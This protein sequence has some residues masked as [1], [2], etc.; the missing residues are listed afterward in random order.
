MANPVLQ[1]LITAKDEASSAFGKLF[2]F[3]DSEV[4]VVAGKIRTAF[5]GLFGGGLD[6]AIEFE[7]QLD[8]VQAKGGYTAD[9]MATLKKAAT[10]I[11]ATFGI[12]G[13]QAAEGMES[14]AAAGLNAEQ[15]METLP[16]VLSLA[17]AEALSMDEASNLLANSLTTVGLGF[18]QAARLADVLTQAANESTTSATAVGAALETA[19]GIARTAGLDLEQTVAA[20]TGLAKGGIEGERAGTALAAILTQLLNPAS[21]ASKELTA[22]GITSRDLG[23]VVGE[24]EKRGA[25]ANTAILAFGETAGPGLRSLIAQG[26]GS[27]TELEQAMLRSGGAAQNAADQMSGNLKGALT[28]LVSAWENVKTAL[29][30]PVLETLAEAARDASTALN[31][32]LNNGALQP[33]QA[34]IKSFTEQG[35][36]AVREFISN[37]DFKAALTSVQGFATNAKESFDS[38]KSAGQT[39]ADV[40]T[41]AWNGLTAGF[42][43]IGA[44]LLGVASS[45]LG[46]LAAIESAAAKVGLGSV[47][48][49]NELNAKALAMK[50]TAADLLNQVATGGREMGVAFERLT[51]STAAAAQAQQTLKDSLPVSEIQEITKTLGDY[52]RIAERTNA[53]AAV[54]T[55]E[56]NAGK[57]SAAEYGAK[58]LAAA[59]ANARLEEETRKTAVATKDSVD[60]STRLANER[61]VEVKAATDAAKASGTYAEALQK[62]GDAAAEVIRAEI[63]LA[64]AKGDVGAAA[65]LA[66]KLAKQEAD[67]AMTVA[68][69]KEEEAR[70][71]QISYEKQKDYLAAVGG[72]T[73]VQKQELELL[74]LKAIALGEEAKAA[75]IGAEIKKLAAIQSADKTAVDKETTQATKENTQATEK[76]SEAQQVNIKHTEDATAAGKAQNE[77]LRQARK[78]TEELSEATRRL[79]DLEFSGAALRAGFDAYRSYRDA[80]T[81]YKDGVDAGRAALT[82]FQTE[83]NNANTLIK[84]SETKILAATSAWQRMDAVIELA[85]GKAKKAFYEQAIA[86][87]NMAQSIDRAMDGSAALLRQVID[88]AESASRGLHLLDEQDLSRLQSAIDAANNKLKQM[89]EETQSAKDRLAELNAELLE[90]QGADDKAQLL[91]QQLD[92]QQALAEIEAQRSQAELEGNRELL[93]TLNQQQQVLEKIN[94]TKIANIEADAKTQA[95]DAGKTSSTSS[96]SASS[97]SSSSGKTYNLNLVGVG[98]KTL[99]ATTTADPAAFLDALESAQRR[100]L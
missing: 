72:G 34:A 56:Y 23:T 97:P 37:F 17:K 14:L 5:T 60:Q 90:A 15:V 29:F 33:V 43:T 25:G 27:L 7:A 3:L 98:G 80:I 52:Q 12:T 13:T 57:I 100:T 38:I 75:Q 54:A 24:L 91:R 71:T 61:Q 66:I 51:G 87:E 73:E 49:A 93:N 88:H 77:Y 44:A 9:S 19:G 8:K 6:G 78:S 28:A 67:T 31:D 26:Q 10:E 95:Q 92:Y 81:A 79:F 50:A 41:I 53:A 48:R 64:R 70:Q 74:R 30:D 83:L 22:L 85:A 18:D 59:E 62:S 42:R 20:L 46:N 63:A 82:T 96:S 32:N 89:Q 39:A 86:A 21:A 35:V 55:A 69:A 2:K 84:Q 16:S 45:V 58:L 36:I 4:S 68:K 94:R 40:V 99:S 11:G 1:F 65:Y 47:E 76:N